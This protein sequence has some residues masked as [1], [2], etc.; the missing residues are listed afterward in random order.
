[1]KTEK[2]MEPKKSRGVESTDTPDKPIFVEN[3]S[4]VIEID[5]KDYLAVAERL[6]QAIDQSDFYS[7]S[8]CY[9][10][11]EFDSTFTATLIVYRKHERVV[12]GIS[13]RIVDIVPVWW[14]FNTCRSD[15]TP[16]LNDF[17]FSELKPYLL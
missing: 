4:A 10:A 2:A 7:G 1:M 3:V 5:K 12:E 15:G 6:L 13:D 17:S 8:I 16:V 14:E 9:N 11:P